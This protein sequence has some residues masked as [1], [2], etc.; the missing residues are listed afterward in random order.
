[1]GYYVC[2]QTAHTLIVG[3][4]ANLFAKE[5]GVP[6]IST[7]ELVTPEAREEWKTF[8]QFH[9]TV[10]VLFRD[11]YFISSCCCHITF[12]FLNHKTNAPSSF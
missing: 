4:G 5:M 8:M 6:E 12:S 7:D 11:R 1:M 10:D 9:K 3:K 2:F